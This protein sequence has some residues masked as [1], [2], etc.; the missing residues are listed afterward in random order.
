MLTHP[1]ITT[2]KA[3]NKFGIDIDQ[4]QDLYARAASLPGLVPSAVAV[5]IGSQM[6]DFAPCANAFRIVAALVTSLRAADIPITHIDLGGGIGVPYQGEAPADLD[7]YADI[8]R[9]TVGDLGCRLAFEPGRFLVA[10]AGLL[11]TRVIAVK[12]GVTRDIVIQDGAMNDLIRLHALRGIPSDADGQGA[13]FAETKERRH[14]WAG[15]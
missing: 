4:A 7:A 2:G 1:K 15:L 8:V 6:L 12:P 3:E 14:C 10:E 9:R 11:L 13:E 5:H